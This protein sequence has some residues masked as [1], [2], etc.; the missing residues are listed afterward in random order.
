MPCLSHSRPAADDGS[1]LEKIVTLD[2]LI[3]TELQEEQA[4][5]A[6]IYA[7]LAALFRQ[8]PS[9]ELLSWLSELELEPS[10]Q[11]ALDQGWQFVR[12][13]ARQTQV[14]KV[15]QE[16]VNVF[17]GIGQ[18]EVTPYASWYLTGSLME[19]PL[20]ELRRD[21]RLLGFERDAT[22]KEPED[23]IAALLELMSYLLLQGTSR[24]RQATFF[25]RHL[26]SWMLP[27]CADVQK[28]PSAVFY[29]A[30]GS[31]AQAFLAQEQALLPQPEEQAQAVQLFVPPPRG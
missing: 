25:Y 13:A 24:Q 18:G 6:D 22:Y 27:F 12:L 14:A 23:H 15:E 10:G 16:Y 20:I 31:L 29:Q 21:L 26:A 2:A 30:V 8:P 7:L 9:A 1:A 5:R 3:P 19:A 28:A 17:I 4:L 11:P